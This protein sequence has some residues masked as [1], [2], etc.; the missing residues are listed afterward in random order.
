MLAQVRP[1]ALVLFGLFAAFYVYKPEVVKYRVKSTL[2]SLSYVLGI[3]VIEVIEDA[4]PTIYQKPLNLPEPRKLT[5]P[6][7]DYMENYKAERQATSKNVKR[8]ILQ[9]T[10]TPL[11]TKEVAEYR[12]ILL[13]KVIKSELVESQQ[14]Q[15]MK[16]YVSFR[17]NVVGAISDFKSLIGNTELC[18]AIKQK[19]YTYSPWIISNDQAVVNQMNP[20]KI[21]WE[22]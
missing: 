12:L 20:I 14:Y 13:H 9:P 11:I 5:V 7:A 8:R 15:G 10:A 3:N 17:I 6:D 2:T 1:Y 18:D 16:C 19:L 22:G 21:R 4:A